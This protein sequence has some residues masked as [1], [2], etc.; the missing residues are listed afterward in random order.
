MDASIRGLIDRLAFW[1]LE[2]GPTELIWFGFA[3]LILGFLSVGFAVAGGITVST[4]SVMKC[5]QTQA[6]A[7][8]RGNVPGQAAGRPFR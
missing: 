2:V 6:P 7:A 8:A 5:L 4:G 1:R 3:F